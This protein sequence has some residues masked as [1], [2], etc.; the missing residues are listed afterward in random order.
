MAFFKL[1]MVG[2]QNKLKESKVDN[3]EENRM[4]ILEKQLKDEFASQQVNEYGNGALGSFTKHSLMRQKHIRNPKGNHF[5]MQLR[6]NIKNK[7]FLAPKEIFKEPITCS[8]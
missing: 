5:D 4:E 1:T 3:A 2:S 6:N 7:E 8:Q